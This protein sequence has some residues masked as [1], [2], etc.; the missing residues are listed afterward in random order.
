MFNPIRFIKNFLITAFISFIPLFGLYLLELKVGE[1]NLD[2]VVERQL[3]DSK[4]S[5]V[6]LSGIN[7][8][9][10]PYKV[11]LMAQSKPEVLAIG[12]S[13]AMQVRGEF[14]NNK[15]TNLG[16]AIQGVAD[17]E[18]ISTVLESYPTKLELALLFVDPWWFN[19]EY[20]HNGGFHQPDFP[21]MI[22]LHLLIDTAKLLR[23][24]NW[25][26]ASF[27]SNNLGIQAILT[28]DGFSRDGSY[29]YT[30]LFGGGGLSSDVKFLNTL[31]RIEHSN[32]RFEKGDRPNPV[33]MSRACSAIKRIKK[34]IGTVIIIAPPF[35][36]IVWNKMSES[37]GYAYIDQANSDLKQCVGNANFYEYLSM[38][39]VPGASDCEFIDGF[40]GGD[41]TYARILKEVSQANAPLS[42]VL[43]LNFIDQFISKNSGYASG[44]ARHKFLHG[45]E[46]DFLKIGCTKYKSM[47]N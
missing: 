23:K 10:F 26:A 36:G 40:H 12:S 20:A 5:V 35:A 38:E 34:N 22:S 17:L 11:K 28:G 9:Q 42:N 6:F 4:G 13:R 41:V 24:G 15:F 47:A 2:N 27:K 44:V 16:G 30:S 32:M 3:A 19:T 43:N 31:E 18:D 46:L 29:N 8:Q 39:K 37:K 25:I 21:E 33:L 1:V 45:K 7:Q 14:F